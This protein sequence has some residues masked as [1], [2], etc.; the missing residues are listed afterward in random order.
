MTEREAV[1][2]FIKGSGFPLEFFVADQLRR[3]GFTPRHGRTYES[4]GPTGEAISREIDVL[5]QLGDTRAAFPVQVVV[6][7]KHGRAPWVVIAGERD[8]APIVLPIVSHPTARSRSPLS[9]AMRASLGIVPPLAFGLTEVKSAKGGTRA[10]A[11]GSHLD[12]AFAAIRQVLSAAT[13][14]AQILERFG[15][16]TLLYPVIVV[17]GSLWLY[18]DG[19]ELEQVDKVRLVWWGSPTGPSGT[20]VDVVT[21]DGFTT[22]YTLGLRDEL[23]ALT[24]AI[25]TLPMDDL[26]V[27]VG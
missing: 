22:D 16:M 12:Q 19:S 7:C 4:T 14:T 20:A 1:E 9:G 10:D 25:N 15:E 8:P 2:A 3:S 27:M 18:R 11:G 13:G 5:A 23:V 6:E 24:R 21:R 26:P 17:E